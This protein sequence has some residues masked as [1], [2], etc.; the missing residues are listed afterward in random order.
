MQELHNLEHMPW[1]S[2]IFRPVRKLLS[3]RQHGPCLYLELDDSDPKPPSCFCKIHFNIFTSFPR[4]SMWS[5]SFVF[6]FKNLGCSAL[7]P[8]VHHIS[9]SSYSWCDYLKNV[10]WGVQI[11][12]LLIMV[13]SPVSYFFLPLKLKYFHQTIG[14]VLW[15]SV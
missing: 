10:W 3:L 6:P 5:L 8:A 4:Y 2:K 12:N 9:H 11:M 13:F 1:E 14:Q 15:C 7:L